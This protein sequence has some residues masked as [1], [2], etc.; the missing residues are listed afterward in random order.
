MTIFSKFRLKTIS[1]TCD[2]YVH[3][4][5]KSCTDAWTELFYLSISDALRINMT[6]Y[7]V[8]LIMRGRIPSEKD[9]KR[10]LLG[11]LQSSAFLS[12]HAFGYAVCN[13]TLR[14]IFGNYNVLTA[15]FIPSFISNFFAI[16]VERP[17]RRGLLSLY[18][19]NVAS[20][21]LFHMAVWR[22][23]VT[24]IRYGE[25]IIFITSVS[26]LLYCYRTQ[27]NGKDPVYSLLR[28]FVGPCEEQG[29]VKKQTLDTEMISVTEA[30]GIGIESH[31]SK[32]HSYSNKK[33]SKW[34]SLP[35]FSFIKYLKSLYCHPTCPHNHSCAYYS[36]Q[37][38][39]KLFTVGYG[40]QLSLKLLL[41]MKKLLSKPSRIPSTVFNVNVMR[42]GAFFG[43]FSGL[44]RFMS[45]LLRRMC[46]KDSQYFALPSGLIAGLSFCFFRDNTVALYMMWKALQILYVDGVGKG[47][48]PEFPHASVFFHCFST[49]VL[50]HAALFEPHN[51]RSSYWKFLY[52]M[53]GGRIA[54]MNRECLDPFGLGSSKSLEIVLKKHK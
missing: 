50:F 41:R 28:F 52:S 25:V 14:R 15:S 6:A 34:D 22:K 2:M 19:T 39:I 7:V 49:A 13:C 33:E 4:W 24:P 44:Y 31:L 23:W 46:G 38:F 27:C 1:S 47:I 21:T 18:V 10:T 35:I 37:G 26:F 8:A 3:P 30:A 36:L 16:F 43:G 45:C 42:L 5:S 17:S 40:L 32:Q 12:C 29:Y 9:L 53:S 51:L 48:F 54:E 20:E 11:I